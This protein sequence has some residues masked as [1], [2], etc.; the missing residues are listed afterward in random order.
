MDEEG[1]RHE[2]SSGQG[3]DEDYDAFDIDPP[4][5]TVDPDEIDPIDSRA[6]PDLLDESAFPSEQIDAESLIDIGVNYVQINRFE[7]AVDAFE[8]AAR[9]SDDPHV[10]QEAWVNKGVAHGEL[11][12]YDEAIGAYREALSIDEEGPFSGEAESNLA[13]ALWEIGRD[14]AALEHAERAVERDPRLPQA[15][16]NRAII[17]YERGLLEDARLSIENADRLG[18]RDPQFL[19][20][21]VEVLEAVGEDEAAE[22]ALEQAVQERERRERE[23]VE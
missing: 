12:E 6:I 11:E 5:L 1:D 4:V 14:E 20:L 9:F 2:F 3:F 23:L 19:D 10:Q 7:Q 8:R 13:Y 17:A 15:W 22:R 18:L 16:F 21:K